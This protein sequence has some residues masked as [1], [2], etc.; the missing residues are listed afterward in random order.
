MTTEISSP[1]EQLTFDPL[2]FAKDLM[3]HLPDFNFK[4]TISSVGRT[5]FLATNLE[6]RVRLTI[7]VEIDNRKR[8]YS[9]D[10]M[11]EFR[12]FSIEYR[13]TNNRGTWKEKRSASYLNRLHAQTQ[14]PRFRGKKGVIV[15]MEEEQAHLIG[16]RDT[17]VAEI[18]GLRG[19]V[20]DNAPMKTIKDLYP[21][22]LFDMPSIVIGELRDHRKVVICKHGF[23]E[24]HV[25]S[26]VSVK[27]DLKISVEE[28][29]T[30]GAECWFLIVGEF[31]SKA[32]GA[33]PEIIVTERDGKLVYYPIL[34]GKITNDFQPDNTFID[35]KS[36]TELDGK[37][38][39]QAIAE[40]MK[41]L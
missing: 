26:I 31:A 10:D 3:A 17:L 20:V 34:R 40:F 19:E 25:R 21:P 6:R 18:N 24:C 36:F 30:P 27:P 2:A 39:E 13:L 14:H 32:S 38:I 5:R 29:V 41:K 1:S 37:M 12:T 22:I 28:A 15:P 35:F 9:S 16:C 7:E 8:T 11:D 23:V 33:T 4:K